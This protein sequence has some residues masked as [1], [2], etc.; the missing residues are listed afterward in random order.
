MSKLEWYLWGADFMIAGIG[1]HFGGPSAALVCFGIGAI[2][3]LIG[4]TKGARPRWRRAMFNTV[5]WFHRALGIEQTWVFVLV[6]ALSSGLI[7]TLGG[8]VV[9]WVVARAYKNSAE[10]KTE[11]PDPKTQTA[12]ATN[13]SASQGVAVQQNT[14][15]QGVQDTTS[16]RSAATPHKS[17]PISASKPKTEPNTSTPPPPTYGQKCEESAC[18]QGPGSQA[19]YNQYAPPP[20]TITISGINQI[21]ASS[22]A[23]P[24]ASVTFYTD[25]QDD[26]GQFEI[27]CDRA[28]TPVDICRLIGSNASVLATVSD[29]VHLAEFLFRRQFPAR[30]ECTLTVESRDERSVIIKSLGLSA[31]TKLVLNSVQPMSSVVTAGSVMQ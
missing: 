19:T 18:A 26:A 24:R 17:A 10:Y 5:N 21:A 9:A 30:T 15:I 7:A 27:V 2:L 12:T 31:R 13:N 28:C 29:D 1:Y 11:H 14:S 8:G 22:G 20:A 3:I 6:I 23:R 16:G 4:L 25:K